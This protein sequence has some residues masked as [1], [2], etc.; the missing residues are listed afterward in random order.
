MF[1][2]LPLKIIPYF[3]EVSENNAKHMLW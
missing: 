2:E 3:S 1:D